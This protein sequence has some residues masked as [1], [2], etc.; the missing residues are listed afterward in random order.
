MN[1][2]KF[3]E[4]TSAA[5]AETRSL[6]PPSGNKSK[7]DLKP[8]YDK[9]WAV[10]IGINDYKSMASLPNAVTDADGIARLLVTE[11]GF[12]KEQVLVVLDPPT[13]APDP[14]YKLIASQASKEVI[15]GLLINDLRTKTGPEDRVIIFFSGHG[16]AVQNQ[17][18]QWFGFLAPVGAN[19][20]DWTTLIE[21]TQIVKMVNEFCR[22]KHV[23]YLLDAC[24]SGVLFEFAKGGIGPSKDALDTMLTRRARM[25][26]TAG[27]GEQVVLTRG[28]EGYSPFTSYV[29]E[30]LRGAAADPPGSPIITGF[31]LMMYVK[32]QVQAN[33]KQMP[34]FG[35]LEGHLGGDFVFR[36][37][38]KAAEILRQRALAALQAGNL[39][40]FR[41]S[42]EQA[43][44]EDSTSLQ[45]RCLEYRLLLLDGRI[46]EAIEVMDGLRRE[47]W[48]AGQSTFPGLPLSEWDVG[49][50][51]RKLRYW[52]TILA[53][54]PGAFPVQVKALTGPDEKHLQPAIEA[55]YG[56]QNAYRVRGDD[57]LYFDFT[58]PTEAA[59][60]LY[61][62]G[63][64]LNGHL[65]TAPLWK[66]RDE[67]L[68][69]GLPPNATRR[70][71]GLHHL[72]GSGF[73]EIRLFA[74][75]EPVPDVDYPPHPDMAQEP[76]EIQDTG[77]MTMKRVYVA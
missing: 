56:Q 76:E 38:S 64:H 62:I 50:I 44:K 26:L 8:D 46:P 58:N 35:A 7:R 32:K 28:R 21:T 65:I 11:L 61:W 20:E 10:V 63:I 48:S 73:F 42:A 5:E 66:R 22:A 1:D 72:G 75:P 70:S 30:G 6:L 13:G 53:I 14:P 60:H 23:F 47:F 40:Q 52:R 34:Q 3:D 9:S 45:A 57:V 16:T 41:Q 39:F 55:Q 77:R 25:A 4:G 24:S 67:T 2:G 19:P 12:P 68:R 51:L 71:E 27:T 37:P 18:G 29:L 74:S 49:D 17:D 15:E 43:A 36:L 31:D 69:K 33:Y 54:T 59:I